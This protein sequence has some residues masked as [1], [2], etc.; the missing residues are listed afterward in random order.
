MEIPLRVATPWDQ[1]WDRRSHQESYPACGQVDELQPIQ[2][3]KERGKRTDN[4]SPE[5][6]GVTPLG[7]DGPVIVF[8]EGHDKPIGGRCDE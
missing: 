2:E 4:D 7:L 8:R 1:S 3:R 5:V 6:L